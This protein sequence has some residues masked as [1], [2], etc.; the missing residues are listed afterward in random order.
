MNV[1]MAIFK[2]CIINLEVVSLNGYVLA[3]MY[4]YGVGT[5]SLPYIANA[6]LML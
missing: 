1:C 6:S 4:T 2:T 3:Y 5:I